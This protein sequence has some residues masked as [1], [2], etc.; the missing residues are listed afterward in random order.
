MVWNKRLEAMIFVWNAVT[1]C[2]ARLESTATEFSMMRDQLFIRS[3]WVV[4]LLSIF[5]VMFG[6]IC[7]FAQPWV[8]FLL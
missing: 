5:R 3:P 7:L 8:G 1:Q 2:R 6:I 4:W